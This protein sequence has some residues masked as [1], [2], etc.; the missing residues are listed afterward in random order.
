MIKMLYVYHD[1][2]TLQKTKMVESQKPRYHKTL[3]T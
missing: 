3:F 2:L 1:C